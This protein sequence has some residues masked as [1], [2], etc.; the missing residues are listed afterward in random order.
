M[1]KFPIGVMLES[2]KQETNEAI[3][4]AVKIGAKGI[5]MYATSGEHAPENMS[6]QER[7][8]LLNRLKDN[9]LV[10]S[11]LCGDLGKGFGNAE[12]NGEL[13]EKSKRIMDMAIELETNIVTTHIGVVPS[14]PS[15]PR[16]K[17]MQDACYQLSEYADTL[18]AHFAVETGPERAETLKMFLDSLNSKGVAVNL[19]PANLVM[20]T[21]DDPV[22]AVD[23]LKDYIVHT[24]AKDGNKLLDGNPEYI[25]QVVHPIPVEFEGKAYFEEVPLGTGS[26]PF[27]KYLNAL[28]SIGY[29][30]FLTIEREVG[31]TPYKDIKTAYDFLRD[32]ENK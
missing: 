26:V 12:I 20:V 5:Q 13:I 28:E 24:H 8:D 21:G 31:E 25:Y 16:Y 19:D 15:H 29:K 27:E 14:D 32:L 30:G 7:R 10:F 11:A 17:I 22:K 18:N 2:F 23:T 6:K 1:Y 9:G 3:A 4:S